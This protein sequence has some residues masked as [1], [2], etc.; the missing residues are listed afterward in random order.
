MD[1][2]EIKVPVIPEIDQMALDG[3]VAEL[4]EL[5]VNPFNVHVDVVEL[6]RHFDNDQQAMFDLLGK[7]KDF[8]A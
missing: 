7:L 6:L 4:S 8:L 5:N 2:P 3:V 1:M